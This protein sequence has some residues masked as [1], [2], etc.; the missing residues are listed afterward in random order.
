LLVP[1]FAVGRA[2]ELVYTLHALIGRGEAPDVPI[3]VDSPM[4]KLATGVY[5]RHPECFDEETHRQ[6]AEGEGAPFGFARLRYV[7]SPQESMALNEREGPCIIIAASGMCEGG[8]IL[9]HLAHGLGDARNTVL[10]VGYQAEGTLGRRIRDGATTVP[11]FGARVER[12]AEVAALDGFSAHADQHELVAWVAA[13][14][15]APR[16]IFLVHGELGPA[17]TL[18]EQLRA[19]VPAEVRIPEKNE[20]FALWN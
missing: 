6:L 2:Q 10:F 15:P 4:A 1:S 16:Q 19:R 9:H 14:D 17:T 20:E 3:F 8:R 13:L 7:S 18:A 11:I 5:R 12:R